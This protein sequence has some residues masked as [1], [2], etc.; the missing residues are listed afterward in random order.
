ME[1]L[2]CRIARGEIPAAKL[3]E[4]DKTMAF[5]DIAPV[6]PGHALVIAKEHYENIESIPEELLGA[7]IGTVK[8][9]GAALK[10]GLGI[11]GY[12]IQVNNDP[13]AGRIIPHL[14]FHVIPRQAGDGHQLWAQ[15]K[16]GEGEMEAV[17]EKIKNAI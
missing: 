2:F 8:K 1:C 9:V 16:Y 14:H 7:V 6:N 3:Y 10:N 15:K 12:N 11:E 4:D 13:I 5:L 17:A